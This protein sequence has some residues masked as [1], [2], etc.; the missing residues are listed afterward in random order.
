MRRGHGQLQ[1]VPWAM[2]EMRGGSGGQ[3]GTFGPGL[4]SRSCGLMAQPV[5]VDPLSAQGRM[6]SC[7]QGGS[8][9]L[10]LLLDLAATPHDL[11]LLIKISP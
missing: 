10:P 11:S 5:A 3:D 2:V 8:G 1:S 4:V 7:A 9:G 6:A